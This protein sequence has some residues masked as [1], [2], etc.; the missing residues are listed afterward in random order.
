[1][2]SEH[3]A[4]ATD[5]I[6]ALMPVAKNLPPS[7][8]AMVMATGIVSIAAFMLG[9]RWVAIALFQVLS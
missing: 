2:T 7:A 5:R 4:A 8:F 3:A 6:P 1:M 9:M